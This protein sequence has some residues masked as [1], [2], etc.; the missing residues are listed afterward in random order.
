ML[1]E[2]DV[3]YNLIPTFLVPSREPVLDYIG[4]VSPR[5]QKHVRHIATK[6]HNTLEKQ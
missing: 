1:Q 5:L 3:Q 6:M 2:G 4:R